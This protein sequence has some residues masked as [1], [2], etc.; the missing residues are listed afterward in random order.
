MAA[1]ESELSGSSAR[2]AALEGELSG[3]SAQASDIQA[4]LEGTSS[5]THE[6]TPASSEVNALMPL[7]PPGA[8]IATA[9][10]FETV[11]MTTTVPTA[12]LGGSG[13][14]VVV[15]VVCQLRFLG[16]FSPRFACVSAEGWST[17]VYWWNCGWQWQ[18]YH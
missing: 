5:R 4:L 15:R 17:S 7:P 16:C 12:K 18:W 2:V 1:L 11:V 9:N 8:G 3:S 13:S 6:S 10:S 14:S